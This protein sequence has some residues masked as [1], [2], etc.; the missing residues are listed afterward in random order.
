MTTREII[1]KDK[2]AFSEFDKDKWFRYYAA[3]NAE[4]PV[5]KAKDKP[6]FLELTD[7]EKMCYQN[8]LDGLLKD[9]KTCPGV[10]YELNY[11]EFE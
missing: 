9:R 10:R 5:E 7:S 8:S 3:L 4:T 2:S 11:K 6:Y 1:A